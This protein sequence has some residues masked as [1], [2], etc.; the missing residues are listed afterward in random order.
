M[1]PPLL[2]SNQDDSG[3]RLENLYETVDGHD[4]NTL[5]RDQARARTRKQLIYGFGIALVALFVATGV[6]I[7]IWR[8]TCCFKSVSKTEVIDSI[9]SNISTVEDF[10]DKKVH[11][12]LKILL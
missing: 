12:R 4:P 10:K 2:E 3:R 7:G 11:T 6:G 9:D 1:A 5:Q 8:R